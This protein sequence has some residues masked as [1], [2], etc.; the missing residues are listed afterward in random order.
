MQKIRIDKKERYKSL[1][2]RIDAYKPSYRGIGVD[3]LNSS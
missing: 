3:R 1:V 2:E